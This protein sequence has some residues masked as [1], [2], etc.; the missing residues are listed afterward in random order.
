MAYC[1]A[2]QL[3][4]KGD[5]VWM[6]GF[7]SGYKCNSAVWKCI[8]PSHSADSAW[9]HPSGLRS[10][11]GD[12]EGAAGVFH[13]R[14]TDRD[15][16]GSERRCRWGD[17]RPYRGGGSCG[18]NWRSGAAAGHRVGSDPCS[19]LY[20]LGRPR[21]AGPC[22]WGP[23]DRGGDRPRCRGGGG[24][25]GSDGGG[26]DRGGCPSGRDGDSGGNGGEGVRPRG[27]D[28]DSGSGRGKDACLGGCDEGSGGGR[29][30]DI[31][32]GSRD[33]GSGSGGG[34]GA[35]S[36]GHDR[37][38][39]ACPGG[40]DEGCG[41][42]GNTCSGSRDVDGGGSGR[43]GTRVGIDDV[44]DDLNKDGDARAGTAARPAAS[45]ATAPAPAAA[46]GMAAPGAAGAA[47]TL[48]SVSPI[49]RGW[50]GATLR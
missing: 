11:A 29:G 47:S 28:G 36:G 19:T 9:C 2:K 34:G 49:P 16:A 17:R 45:G 32:P 33:K 31:R 15:P 24:A 41:G 38:G 23:S 12:E 14:G 26:G 5:R 3:M 40:C 1:E 7:G 22:P 21:G 46:S 10:I 43:V 4:R 18:G 42:D 44:R 13:L 30:G 37:G 39:D 6:I 48:A 35:C 27:H 8:L 25:C 50:S 20:L